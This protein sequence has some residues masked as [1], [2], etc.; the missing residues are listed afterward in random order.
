MA[1]NVKKQRTEQRDSNALMLAYLCVKDVEG[2]GER[3]SILDRFGFNDSDLAA[4][5]DVGEKAVRDARY[6][7]KQ[8][9]AKGIQ[10]QG[11]KK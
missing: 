8:R 5:C 7:Q 11:G 4:V 3:I 6:K 2:L 10:A 1:T 9:S